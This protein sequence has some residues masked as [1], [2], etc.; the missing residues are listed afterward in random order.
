MIRSGPSILV[1]LTGLLVVVGLVAPL[2]SVRVD[3]GAPAQATVT[4][5]C[6]SGSIT[7]T[8][9]LRA[10][11]QIAH[12]LQLVTAQVTGHWFGADWVTLTLV[13][14][15]ARSIE[16]RWSGSRTSQVSM[17]FLA[18]RSSGAWQAT[19]AA[20]GEGTV[21]VDGHFLYGPGGVVAAP[22]TLTVAGTM[23]YLPDSAR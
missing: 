9:V 17:R 5:E 20:S 8:L 23:L 22:I 3:A 21:C 12:G 13:K 4:P 16:H 18:P 2:S 15:G 19:A 14:P 10:E 6:A 1:A 7:P 11:P